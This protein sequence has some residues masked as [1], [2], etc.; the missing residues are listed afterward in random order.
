MT[1]LV[2]LV[3]C[4][5]SF[6][7]QNDLEAVLSTFTILSCTNNYCQSACGISFRVHAKAILDFKIVKNIK[8]ETLVKILE[9]FRFRRGLLTTRARS[10]FKG[11]LFK[12]SR[13]LENLWTSRSLCWWVILKRQILFQSAPNAF[14]KLFHETK[15]CLHLLKAFSEL[16]MA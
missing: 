3:C 15:W 9:T 8:N 13:G 2:F 6:Y 10:N 5:P 7:F 4:L 1:R 14:M 11:R 16:K 12:R